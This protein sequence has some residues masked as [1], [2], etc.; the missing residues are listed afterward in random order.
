MR[1]KS[2]RTPHPLSMIERMQQ[3]RAGIAP[4]TYCAVHMVKG[5]PV[6]RGG[7]R[8]GTQR[9]GGKA[10]GPCPRYA[11]I[12]VDDTPLCEAHAGHAAH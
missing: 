12:L 2:I 4:G 3:E 6:I 10:I 11:L 9:N 5:A 1:R 8:V 7:R